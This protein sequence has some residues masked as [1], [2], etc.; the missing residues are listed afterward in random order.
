MINVL[1]EYIIDILSFNIDIVNPD[2]ALSAFVNHAF[3][4]YTFSPYTC[5]SNV[6]VQSILTS[7]FF[8]V[9]FSWNELISHRTRVQLITSK[10]S[11]K[12]PLSLI[13]QS[14]PSRSKQLNRM[15]ASTLNYSI[16][17]GRMNFNETST[18]PS[19]TERGFHAFILI[20][21]SILV[22]VGNAL[23]VSV[24]KLDRHLHKPTFYFLV[25]LAA[26]D[27]MIGALYAPFYTV[28]VIEQRWVFA[29]AWCG[30]HAFLISASVN[31][32]ILTLSLVSFDR[33]K[34]ITN[35]LR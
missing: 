15:P 25:N 4:H 5:S 35:P 16:H 13:D 6:Q 24:V 32:S 12:S 21:I 11:F 9:L 17:S 22:I 31:A 28:A 29:T 10:L 1:V 7:C 34:D 26:A 2:I 23:V 33:F 19:M 3:L 20:L 18:L 8:R 14:L 27:L 30:G